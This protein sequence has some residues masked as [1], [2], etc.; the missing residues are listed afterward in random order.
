MTLCK[1]C[2]G[3]MTVLAAPAAHAATPVLYSEGNPSVALT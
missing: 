2:V 3:L 1:H